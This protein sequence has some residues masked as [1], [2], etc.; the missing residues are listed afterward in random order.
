MP[1]IVH[2]EKNELV[3]MKWVLLHHGTPDINTAKRPINA[4]TETLSEKPSFYELMKNRRCLVPASGFFKWK[5]EGKKK[6]PFYIYLP[7][8]PLF[9]FAGVY[10]YLAGPDGNLLFSYM[11]IITEPNALTVKI[12]NRILSIL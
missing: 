11:I 3:M 7:D 1:V 9:A 6:V 10:D 5:K 12:H 8:T 4:R 2:K